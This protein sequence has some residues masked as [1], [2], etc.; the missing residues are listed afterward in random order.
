VIQYGCWNPP[1]NNQ[2]W[3]SRSQIN[4]TARVYEPVG[5]FSYQAQFNC[6]WHYNCADGQWP[7]A[8]PIA[9]DWQFPNNIKTDTYF[10]VHLAN[11]GAGGFAG[12]VRISNHD[13]MCNST[14]AEVYD[15]WN[16]KIG[17]EVF[18]HTDPPTGYTL[19]YSVNLYTNGNTSARSGN[20]IAPDPL[21]CDADEP[22]VHNFWENSVGWNYVLNPSIDNE[23]QCHGCGTQANIWTKYTHQFYFSR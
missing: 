22:H 8:T 11:A 15:R 4:V 23:A 20:Y 9:L 14:I 6:G 3:L 19:P 12:Q 17:R 7:D 10:R 18:Y 5:D 21:G 2:K 1:T 16:A 13:Q